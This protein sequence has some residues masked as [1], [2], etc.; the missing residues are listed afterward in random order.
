MALHQHRLWKIKLQL[1][2]CELERTGAEA[3]FVGHAIQR[4]RSVTEIIDVQG[5]QHYSSCIYAYR[6]EAWE[7]DKTAGQDSSGKETRCL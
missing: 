5:M 2:V 4:S 6:R 3:V 1:S 7:V